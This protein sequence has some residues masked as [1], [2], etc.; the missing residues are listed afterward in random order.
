VRPEDEVIA[1]YERELAEVGGDADEVEEPTRRGGG[2]GFWMVA[3]ALALG[4]VLLVT[5]IFANLSIKETIAH[6]QHTLLL[7]RAEANEVLANT[8][9]YAGASPQRLATEEPSLTYRS[10]DEPSTGLNDVSVAASP[11]VW[12][13]AVRAASDACFTIR[14]EAGGEVRYGAG[15]ECTGSAALGAS[16]PRW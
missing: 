4:C 12:A 10:A 3:G 2:R 5:Q 16:A 1:A 13:A 8:G 9:S 6:A 11:T 15:E 7:A 14:L